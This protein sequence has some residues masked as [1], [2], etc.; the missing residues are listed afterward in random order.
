MVVSY[1]KLTNVEADVIRYF[2]W[3]EIIGEDEWFKDGMKELA[4]SIKRHKKSIAKAIATLEAKGMIRTEKSSNRLCVKHTLCNDEVYTR[5]AFI[6]PM[7]CYAQS[8]QEL[9]EE[10]QEEI[11][12][13]EEEIAASKEANIRNNKR[14]RV[15]DKIIE[16]V[17][18]SEFEKLVLHWGEMTYANS[19]DSLEDRIMDAIQVFRD[20][21]FGRYEEKVVKGISDESEGEIYDEFWMRNNK[22]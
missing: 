20:K 6:D 12:R 7:F 3:R 10:L 17:P 11:N 1:Q 14:D 22:E 13:L 8:V 5:M 9:R 2:I 16:E 4:L 21:V 15:I 19:N 18:E